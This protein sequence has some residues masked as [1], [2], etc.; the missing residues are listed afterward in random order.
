MVHAV[1]RSSTGALYAMKCMDKRMI[2]LK[3][4][5]RMILFE[6]DLLASVDCPFV[7]SLQFAFQTDEEVFFA[8]DLKS[9]AA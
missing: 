2:K 7:T 4:S 1:Q 9:G 6:R 5:T 8:L 3:H